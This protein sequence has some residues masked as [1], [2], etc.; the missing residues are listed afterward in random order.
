M[1]KEF[2]REDIQMTNEHMPRC[3]T[4]RETPIKNT[5]RYH[6]AHIRMLLLKEQ[7]L[8]V[9]KEVALCTVGMQGVAA[10]AENCMEVPPDP[11]MQLPYDLLI[12]LLGI[13]PKGFKAGSLLSSFPYFLIPTSCTFTL[14]FLPLNT[15]EFVIFNL[16]YLPTQLYLCFQ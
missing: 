12:L 5:V 10:T 14:P 9:G 7:K 15:N 8:S 1:D 16:D 13:Y 3:L 11:E 2:S 4:S 6:L